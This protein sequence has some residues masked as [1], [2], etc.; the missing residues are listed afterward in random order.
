MIDVAKYFIWNVIMLTALL[1]TYEIVLVKL[2]GL[3]GLLAMFNL[4]GL[5]KWI[6]GLIFMIKYKYSLKD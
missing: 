3:L 5:I 1:I 4:L 6:P 2:F